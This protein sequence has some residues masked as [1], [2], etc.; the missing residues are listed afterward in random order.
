M[1]KVAEEVERKT[2]DI[3]YPMKVAIM[4]C[5]VNGPGEASDADIGIAGGNG[6]GLI[7][8]KGKPLRQV[9][10]ADMVTA[11]LEEINLFI[12]EGEKPK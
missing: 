5:E 4:G 12:R 11:L 1:Q 8:K 7:F 10:E 3:T 2:K 6:I 9:A